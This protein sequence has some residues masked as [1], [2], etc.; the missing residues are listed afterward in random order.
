MLP[1]PLMLQ[2]Q[3]Q[4]QELAL[5][6]QA[7]EEYTQAAEA[8]AGTGAGSSPA[9][10]EPVNLERLLGQAMR[11]DGFDTPAQA[12]GLLAYYRRLGCSPA[13]LQAA[14]ERLAPEAPLP[15]PGPGLGP[16][17]ASPGLQ[18]QLQVA[19]WELLAAA[20]AAALLA[21][22]Q[23]RPRGWSRQDLLEVRASAIAGRGLFARASI[24]SGTV[25]GAYPGRL[26]S[27]A[28]MLEKCE[29]APMA[30]SYAFRTADGRFLDPTD[31]TGQPSPNPQPGWFWPLPTDISLCFANEPPK[32]SLG[33]NASVEDGAGP[34]DLLFVARADIP[35]GAE[36]L[37]D[38][39]TTYD[40]SGYSR[41]QQ[42]TSM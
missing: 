28:E 10:C 37:I 15:G 29:T 8:A 24:P 22:Y 21:A 3:P 11:M 38:Y 12:D 6:A 32:G 39:G 19:A 2:P 20:V 40:R 16:E 18:G 34:G 1:P 31:L 7:D 25:L 9:F 35:Q 17:W 33:T 26:R 41:G 5:L 36:V 14:V 42:K 23:T 13:Q 4:P 27:G 30:A